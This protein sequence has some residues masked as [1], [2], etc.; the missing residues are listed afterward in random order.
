[1]RVFP[2]VSRAGA[3][4]MSTRRGEQN[5]ISK[6]ST[7]QVH[8]E[9]RWAPYSLLLCLTLQFHLEAIKKN[10]RNNFYQKLMMSN[11]ESG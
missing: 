8:R 9:E 4:G 5:Y 2:S 10:N 1:M 3:W 7:I 11:V 6:C